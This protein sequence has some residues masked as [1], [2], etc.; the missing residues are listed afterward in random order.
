MVE[1]DVAEPPPLVVLVQGPPGVG[2]TT[3]IRNLVKHYVNQN[4]GEVKGP[5]TL[6]AGKTRRLTFVE[7]PQV[8]PKGFPP[9]LGFAAI[10]QI[11][12]IAGMTGHLVGVE[13]PVREGVPSWQGSCVQSAPSLA[14]RFA[15]W[16]SFSCAVQHEEM[17]TWALCLVTSAVRH[18]QVS[19]LAP[20]LPLAVLYNMA[21]SQLERLPFFWRCRTT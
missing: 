14:G 3:L 7:C 2:K 15:I 5:I 18:G 17:S 11:S 19:G 4:L 10:R 6:V 12:L 20:G 16:L 8:C 13:C 21:A 1:Q 9:A